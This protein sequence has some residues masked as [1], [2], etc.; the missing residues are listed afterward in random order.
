MK[1]ELERVPVENSVDQKKHYSI[2]KVNLNY[3]YIFVIEM[4]YDYTIY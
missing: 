4:E 2:R 1:R 3:E